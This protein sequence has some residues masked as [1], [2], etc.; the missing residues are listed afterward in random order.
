MVFVVVVKKINTSIDPDK[1]IHIMEQSNIPM[2]N[3]IKYYEKRKINKQNNTYTLHIK[4]RSFNEENE[5]MC[6][7]YDDL[8]EYK[9]IKLKYDDNTYF[10]IRI[11]EID[12]YNFVYRNVFYN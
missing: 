6:K 11:K 7:F 2:G 12:Y 1:I 3:N 8:I 10:K 4:Y 9:W 5:K